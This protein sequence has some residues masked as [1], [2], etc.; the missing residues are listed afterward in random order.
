MIILLMTKCSGV[1]DLMRK[2]KEDSRLY[3]LTNNMVSSALKN[4]NRIVYQRYFKEIQIPCLLHRKL[5]LQDL[6][7]VP[8]LSTKL[9]KSQKAQK[10]YFMK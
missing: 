8:P 10:Y 3:L 1:L 9:N 2:S 6:S 4:K 7:Q 5:D